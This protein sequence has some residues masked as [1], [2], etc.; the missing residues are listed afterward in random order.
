M[1]MYCFL[2]IK[3]DYSEKLPLISA[4]FEA[5]QG[6]AIFTK[7]DLR[8]AYRLE[9]TLNTLF[10]HFEYLVMPFGLS[11]APAVFQ[12]LV[13]DV[14][15][16]FLHHFVFID[17]DSILFFSRSHQEHVS[18]VCLVLEHLL[19]R[20]KWQEMPISLRVG[21][22]LGLYVLPNPDKM[23]AVSQWPV[24]ADHKQF[25]RFLGFVKFL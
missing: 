9:K 12:T 10:G 11:N 23:K 18:H 22:F 2:G 5:L 25:Q 13:N 6:E 4:A 17:L 21:S 3:S 19:E 16:D 24:P 8:N 14:L 7:L 15:G 20:K 1:P